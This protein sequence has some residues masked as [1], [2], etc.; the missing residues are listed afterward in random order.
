[1]NDRKTGYAFIRL[2]KSKDSILVADKIIKALKPYRGI[3]KTIISDKGKEFVD[4]KKIEKALD[5]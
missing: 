1:M 5:I 2:L 4:F 3:L